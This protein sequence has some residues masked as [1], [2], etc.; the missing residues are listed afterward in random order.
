MKR[1]PV[2]IAC[3]AL[4]V[5]ASGAHAA[6]SA[7]NLFQRP[8]RILVPFAPG[9]GQDTTA[10]LLGAK[11]SELLGQQVIVDNRPGGAGIIAAETALKAPPDGHTM[12]LASTSFVV[13][14]SLQKSLPYDTLKDFAPIMRVSSTPGTLVVHASLPV[15]NVRE[16]VALAKSKPGEL[17]FGSAGVASNSHL[18]GELFKV[19]AGVDMVHVPYKGSALATNALLSGE[20]AVGFSNAIATLPQVRAG[21]LR[22]LAV[23]PAQ[24]SRLLPDVPTIAEA[25][26]PGFENVIWSGVVVNSATPKPAQAALHEAISR[27]LDLPDVKERLARDGSEPFAG[28]TPAQYGAF[29]A[30]EIEKWRKVVQRAGIKPQ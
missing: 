23:T 24:R 20:T 8:L 14:P 10:R 11:M 3:A 12:Y 29:I 13:T 7:K 26:V 27:T 17:T 6:D 21:R 25:G 9:G 5:A 18:S 1:N 22:L 19:L 30:R 2:P 28:D 15:R 4:L 16:L